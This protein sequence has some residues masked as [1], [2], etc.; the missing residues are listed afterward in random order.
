MHHHSFKGSRFCLCSL[1]FV[2]ACLCIKK[3]W[4][5]PYVA[6]FFCA[7]LFPCPMLGMVLWWPELLVLVRLAWVCRG[8]PLK[9]LRVITNR[10]TRPTLTNGEIDNSMHCFL[11]INGFEWSYPMEHASSV[12]LH[13]AF[14]WQVLFTWL[15]QGQQDQ[16]ISTGRRI[17]WVVDFNRLQHANFI[18]HT[19]AAT[20]RPPLFRPL[21]WHVQPQPFEINNLQ[22]V[23][24]NSMN[25]T[26]CWN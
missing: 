26:T 15:L 13:L 23:E 2:T 4:F 18:D 9:L 20:K 19:G 6:C 12:R 10:I 24:I 25:A 17:H 14:R 11:H 21:H 8:T 7:H 5:G 1:G 16:L 3:T 22:P